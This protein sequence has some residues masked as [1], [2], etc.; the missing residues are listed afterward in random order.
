METVETNIIC[1]NTKST[2]RDRNSRETVETN[3]DICKNN[4]KVHGETERDWRILER[5]WRPPEIHA[6]L[7]QKCMERQKETG[8]H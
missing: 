5:L 7:I 8:G 4:T 1:A 2:G 6:I 3:G